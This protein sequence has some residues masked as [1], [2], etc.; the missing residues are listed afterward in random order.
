MPERRGWTGSPVADPLTVHPAA[1]LF[2]LMPVEELRALA[3]DIRANGLIEPVLLYQ[4]QI[5]DGRNRLAACALAGV[6]PRFAVADIPP[7]SSPLLY[8]VSKNLHRRH[9]TV[10]QRATIAVDLMPRLQ[11]EALERKRQAGKKHGK[12]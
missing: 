1:S 7:T 5:L 6:T 9:L 12:A 10:S 4:N 11:D 2:P 3:E 8:A